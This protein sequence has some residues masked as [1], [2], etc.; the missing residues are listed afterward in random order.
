MSLVQGSAQLPDLRLSFLGCN[1]HG[2]DEAPFTVKQ[3]H[4]ALFCQNFRK[5]Y[6]REYV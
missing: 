2:K 5:P 1:G 6:S 4:E 3:I